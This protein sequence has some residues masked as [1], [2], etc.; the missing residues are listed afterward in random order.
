MDSV[1]K[2]TRILVLGGGAGMTEAIK[3]LVAN[4]DMEI[5]TP[6]DLQPGSHNLDM[7]V[8]GDILEHTQPANPLEGLE[9]LLHPGSMARKIQ[10]VHS[11]GLGGLKP[12]TIYIDDMSMFEPDPLIP[13]QQQPHWVK[14]RR[15]EGR[16][17]GFK[18]GKHR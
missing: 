8:D 6:D 9:D 5:L 17:P 18:M 14:R 12:N 16:N 11:Q 7:I 4:R 2:K 3:A 13:V 15:G 10:E 1:N